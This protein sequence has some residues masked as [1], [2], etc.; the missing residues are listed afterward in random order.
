MRNE[1]IEYPGYDVIR[2]S[3]VTM[4]NLKDGDLLTD[5]GHLEGWK[6]GSILGY[7]IETCRD[8]LKALE[9]AL[10]NKDDTIW[11]NPIGA[12][13]S[14]KATK[15]QTRYEIAPGQTFRFHGKLFTLKSAP[16]HNVELVPYLV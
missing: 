5:E 9:Q 14:D 3:Q 4:L 12:V 7:A 11:A 13:I 8:P 6:L 16:N 2:A 1:R 15:G 10:A